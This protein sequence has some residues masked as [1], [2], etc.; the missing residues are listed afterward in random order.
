MVSILPSTL[1]FTVGEYRRSTPI[2]MV[3]TLRDDKVMWQDGE[4]DVHAVRCVGE[5]LQ[6]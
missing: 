5:Q 3:S 6:A 1:K 4:M 2:D